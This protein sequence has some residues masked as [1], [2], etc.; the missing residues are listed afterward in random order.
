MKSIIKTTKRQNPYL[1]SLT[2]FNLAVAK[3]KY[4]RGTINKYFDELVDKK[5]YLPSLRD[6]VLEYTYS[7]SE[8]N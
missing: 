7:L 8:Q 5:D 4:D 1:S 6:A 3:Y 2:V